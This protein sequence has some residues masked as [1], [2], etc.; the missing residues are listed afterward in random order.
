MMKKALAALALSAAIFAVAPANATIMITA[1]P[2]G[3]LATSL[4]NFDTDTPAIA[5]GAFNPPTSNALVTYTSTGQVGVV[6]GTNNFFNVAPTTDTTPYLSVFAG[7]SETLTLTTPAT[8]FGL[9]WGSI[10][11][12]NDLK[13]YNGAT[14]LADISLAQLL[15]T[16]GGSGIIDGVTSEYV[17]ISNLGAGITSVVMTSSINSFESD[18]LEVTSVPEAST[19]AMMLIGFASVGFL[20]YRSRSRRPALR[21]V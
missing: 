4:D 16:P 11:H 14:L 18:N 17:T 1:G 2:T 6:Q 21:L 10:D 12:Y 15:A 3:T 9:Y 7:G 5:P 19:W 8:A 20:S 13:L